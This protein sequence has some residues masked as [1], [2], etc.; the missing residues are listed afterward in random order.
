MTRLRT[1]QLFLEVEHVL[2]EA[3][4][5]VMHQRISSIICVQVVKWQWFNVLAIK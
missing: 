5:L 4:N 2:N 1:L 3:D